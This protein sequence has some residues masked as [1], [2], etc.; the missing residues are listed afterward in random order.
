VTGV[1]AMTTTSETE[2][3]PAA[4]ELRNLIKTYGTTRALDGVSLK[5]RAGSFTA[6]LGPSGS[7]KTTLLNALGGFA[8][9]DSGEVIVDGCDVTR[10]PANRRGVG[11][12]FQ[13]YALFPHMSVEANVAYPLVSRRLPKSE[14]RE[15]TRRVL[16]L[17]ELERLARRHPTQLSGGQK[18]RVALAR[19]LV[20]EPSVILLDEPLAALDRRLRESLRDE[21]MQLHA[22]VGCTFVLVTHDQEE[23]LSMAD[24]LVVLRDG[25]VEQEG[26]PADVYD[27]PQ[28]RFVANFLGDCNLLDG[29][30]T[31]DGRLVGGTGVTLADTTSAPH[32]QAVLRPERLRLVNG[33][34]RADESSIAAT[35]VTQQFVGREVLLRCSSQLGDLLV[36]VP[37]TRSDAHAEDAS[38]PG[39]NIELAWIPRGLHTI[40]S[41]AEAETRQ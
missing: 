38:T 5:I 12:V 13:D 27:I 6:L 22:R 1:Q 16:E 28:T 4:I 37:R 8:N 25:R 30:A 21:L 32:A 41:A 3:A 26:T 15:R 23:A 29:T 39:Q 2:S 11:Y 31:S 18:Q 17:V 33:D 36:R 14:V 10:A 7:G 20:Y 19:A 40:P 34:L 9:L 24:Y 35:V